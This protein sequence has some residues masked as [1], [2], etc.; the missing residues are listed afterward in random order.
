[1]TTAIAPDFRRIYFGCTICGLILAAGELVTA[2]LFGNRP[3]IPF[4]LS[5]GAMILYAASYLPRSRRVRYAVM[6]GAVA[7]SIAYTLGRQAFK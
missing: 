3:D 6:A 2:T 4:L 1:M 5:D 7:L